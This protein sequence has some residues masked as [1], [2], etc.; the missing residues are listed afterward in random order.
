MKNSD[1]SS[2]LQSFLTNDWEKM[3]EEGRGH[4]DHLEQS[5]K[6]AFT[7]ISTNHVDLQEGL[8]N[9]NSKAAFEMSR[10]RISHKSICLGSISY[11]WGL[12]SSA[13]FLL[14]PIYGGL[15][16]GDL[17]YFKFPSS[18][19]QQC[20]QFLGQLL[21]AFRTAEWNWYHSFQP[22]SCLWI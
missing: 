2:R 9:S 16:M 19:L 20:P 13:S 17:Y 4:Q 8:Y 1:R 10:D 5:L 14:T 7:L 3:R 6:M 22:C 15:W 11:I 21:W 18:P 12:L